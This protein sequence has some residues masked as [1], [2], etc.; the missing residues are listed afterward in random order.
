MILFS[1]EAWLENIPEGSRFLYTMPQEWAEP[2]S[3]EEHG[4]EQ[5]ADC[6]IL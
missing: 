2:A 5:A 1:A 3:G 4:G 6:A